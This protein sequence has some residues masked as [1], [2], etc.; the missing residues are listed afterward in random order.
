MPAAQASSRRK[1]FAAGP[2]CNRQHP[3]PIREVAFLPVLKER[4][5]G[6]TVKNDNALLVEIRDLLKLMTEDQQKLIDDVREL[7]NENKK[8]RDEIR[9]SNFVLNNIAA[10][11]EIIN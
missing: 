8:L 9:M 4:K 5:G 10:R 1:A 6:L 7:K 3:G 2:G 11:S